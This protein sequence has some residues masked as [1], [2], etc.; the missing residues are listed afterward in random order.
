MLQKVVITTEHKN[1][2]KILL[3]IIYVRYNYTLQRFITVLGK[4]YYIYNTY[5]IMFRVSCEVINLAK[6]KNAS[7]ST[8]V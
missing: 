6:R 8:D 7:M 3:F 5:Y 1:P 4:I 2:L